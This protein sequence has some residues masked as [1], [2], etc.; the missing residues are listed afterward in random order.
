MAPRI[1]VAARYL[2]AILE[3]QELGGEMAA[4]KPRLDRSDLVAQTNQ[5]HARSGI[6]EATEKERGLFFQVNG[7]SIG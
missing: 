7:F 2:I 1:I 5:V 3:K 6:G 4:W